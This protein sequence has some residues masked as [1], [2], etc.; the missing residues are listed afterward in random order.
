MK[1][2]AASAVLC[3]CNGI[4]FQRFIPHPYRGERFTMFDSKVEAN[5][6]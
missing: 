1:I 2:T 6:L 3:T 5:C 4:M